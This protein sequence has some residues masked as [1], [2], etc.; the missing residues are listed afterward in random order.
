MGAKDHSHGESI[1]KVEIQSC[2]TVLLMFELPSLW[3]VQAQ[4]IHGEGETQKNLHF[5]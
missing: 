4:S 3:S 5:R 2:E 1:A